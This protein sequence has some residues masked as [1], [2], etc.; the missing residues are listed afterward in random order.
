MKTY[1]LYNFKDATDQNKDSA[2]ISKIDDE[3]NPYL[4]DMKITFATY[5]DAR[6]F[7]EQ[8]GFDVSFKKIKHE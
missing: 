8:A 6:M 4:V 7:I 5:E 1:E 2:I 3:Y